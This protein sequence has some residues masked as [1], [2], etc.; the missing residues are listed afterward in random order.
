[1]EVL[2]R[3]ATQSST[4]S[5]EKYLQVFFERQADYY[6]RY[7]REYN[8]GNMFSFN[9]APFIFGMF[10]MLYRKM[11]VETGFVFLFFLATSIAEELAYDFFNLGFDLQQGIGWGINIATAVALGFCGN[12]LYI[13]HATKRIAKVLRSTADEGERIEILAKK[14]GTSSAPFVVIAVLMIVFI[15]IV[16]TR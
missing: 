16:G 1:M 2:D 6:L 11:F 8:S 15:L 7:Y 12:L 13:H 10:W 9:T 3:Y 4:A 14:G 5:E